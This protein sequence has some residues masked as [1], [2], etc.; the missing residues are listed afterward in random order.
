MIVNRLYAKVNR[1]KVAE[2]VAFLKSFSEKHVDT[3]I[4]IY[5]PYVGQNDTICIEMEYEDLAAYEKFSNEIFDSP[6]VLEDWKPWF[7]MTREA[8]N[9]IWEIE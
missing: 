5:S 6:Q 9:E 8:H 2:V 1:G 3:P 4:R 7:E